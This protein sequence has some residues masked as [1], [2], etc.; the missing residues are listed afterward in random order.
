ME[1]RTEGRKEGSKEGRKEGR[2][3]GN[4]EIR[5]DH[6]YLTLRRYT[7]LMYRNIIVRRLSL[8][9]NKATSATAAEMIIK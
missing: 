8:R 4:K 1:G 7:I 2:K 6:V 5:K 9:L 3:E